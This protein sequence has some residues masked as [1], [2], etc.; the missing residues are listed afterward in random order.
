MHKIAPFNTTG[1]SGRDATK[2]ELEAQM[3]VF[4]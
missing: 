4:I 3:K 2:D 1:L